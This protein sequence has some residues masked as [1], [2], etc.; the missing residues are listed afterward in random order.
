MRKSV[1]ILLAIVVIAATAYIAY[2]YFRKEAD[3]PIDSAASPGNATEDVTLQD[4][5]MRLLELGGSTK[6]ISDYSEGILFLNFW[7]TWC[8][9]CE[10]EMPDLIEL[11]RQM[12]SE[13]IGKVVAIDVNEKESVV[14]AYLEKQGFTGLTVLLDLDGEAA[15]KF[16]I[17]G[18]PTTFVFKNGMLMDVKVGMMSKEAMDAMLERAR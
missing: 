2:N 15:K 14:E 11:D 9:Y 7:A 3:N 1:V 4:L 16:D 10:L 13:G 6:R 8:G 5:D 18:Y 17:E 12:R